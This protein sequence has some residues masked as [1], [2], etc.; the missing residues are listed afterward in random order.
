MLTRAEFPPRL[1]DLVDA[2]E[3]LYVLGELTQGPAV[4]VV[5]TRHPTD[6][7]LTFARHLAHDLARA[8]VAII[9]GGA[10]GIDTAAHE[11]ALAARGVTVVMAPASFDRPYPEKNAPLFERIVRE[12]GAYVT[13]YAPGTAAMQH[14]FFARNTLLAALSDVLVVVESKLRG[15]ARNAAK[16]ARALARPVCAV[17]GGPWNVAA[18]GCLAEI[19]MGARLVTSARDVLEAVAIL[20][21]PSAGPEPNPSAPESEPLPMSRIPQS[22]SGD[23]DRDTLLSALARGELCPEELCSLTGLSPGRLQALLLTLTLEG[24]VVSGPSGQFKLRTN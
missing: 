14:H 13:A 19:Q 9:S 8:G 12:G 2:P 3:V 10:I 7:A 23:P 18:Q 22:C 24:I 20:E 15:G 17:P 21:P 4:A 11:G 16:T 6:E 5:G 1:R